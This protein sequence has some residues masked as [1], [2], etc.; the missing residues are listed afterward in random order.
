[1]S[2]PDGHEWLSIM[3]KDRI[4]VAEQSTIWLQKRSRDLQLA[5]LYFGPYWV[6]RVVRGLIQSIRWSCLLSFWFLQ[7]FELEGDGCRVTH[8]EEWPN[9][10][11]CTLIITPKSVKNLKN[12]TILI[13]VVTKRPAKILLKWKKFYYISI[14]MY[15]CERLNT[16]R[17][18]IQNIF[19]PPILDHRNKHCNRCQKNN[20][21]N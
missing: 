9:T 20:W 7:K 3:L 17:D 18:V 16:S 13:E 4:L 11:F 8:A 5:T 12:K 19:I 15:P 10:L 14:N 1:M 6:R 21:E 2:L